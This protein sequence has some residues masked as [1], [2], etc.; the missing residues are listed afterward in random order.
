MTGTMLLSNL[1]ALGVQ[2]TVL[3]AAAA[4]LARAFRIESPKALLAYWRTLLLACL[5]LPLYQP[6]NIVPT[7]PL[8]AAA[9]STPIAGVASSDSVASVTTA[10][11]ASWSVSQFLLAA[12]AAGIV[13]RALWLAL[14]AFGLWALRR[15]ARPLDPLPESVCRAQE[16]TGTHAAMYVSERVSGPITYGHF[17]PVI[18]FPPS[19]SAM[20][21]DVQTAIA[22]H[23][24]LHVRRR[25]WVQELIEEMVRC[26]LWFHPAIWWLI[27]RIQLARE[28][29]VDQ[30]TIALI[31]SRER[32]VESLLAVA[33]ANSRVTFAPASAFFRRRLLKR[34]VARIFQESTMT[35]RRLI[36]SLTAS[37]AALALAITLTVRAFPLEAQGVE[38]PAGTGPVQVL[39][40]GEHLLHGDVPEYPRRA[41]ERSVQGDVVLEMTLNDRGEVSDARVITGPDE[42]R[43]AA[44]EAVLNW[45]YSPEALSSRA[46]QATLRFQ[47]PPAGLRSAEYGGKVNLLGDGVAR[48]TWAPETEAQLAEHRLMEI[49]KALEDVSITDVQRLELKLKLA[50]TERL[51]E[52]MRTADRL[53]GEREARGREVEIVTSGRETLAVAEVASKLEETRD[54]PARLAR[55]RTERVSADTAKEV[56]AHAGIAVGDTISKESIARLREAAR[57]IDEHLVVEMEK[58]SDGLVLTLLAR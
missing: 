21:A 52:E 44:L 27:G 47:L 18:V 38:R 55:I 53:E 48:W 57:A 19:V 22:C 7:S 39:E 46:T 32:Y 50:Q 36:A 23:E 40:G 35:T 1:V 10:A 41:A 13:G 49:S 14:G 25:D 16:Q 45:H 6:W 51:L 15:G 2:M 24:L 9:V 11:S 4:L 30:A 43:R 12:L 17:R 33:S 3:V 34:R 29:V 20:P 28:E 26:A 8:S 56:L 37:A 5:L 58:T 31:D 42:L 54:V